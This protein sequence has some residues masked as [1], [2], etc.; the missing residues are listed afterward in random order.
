VESGKVQHFA[1]GSGVQPRA[2]PVYRIHQVNKH[3]L[4]DSNTDA[5]SVCSIGVGLPPSREADARKVGR[6]SVM[7]WPTIT[8]TE[9]TALARLKAPP[10]VPRSGMIFSVQI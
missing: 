10:K 9:F 8:S 5:E 6:R 7:T 2:A 1:Q 3:M 4:L